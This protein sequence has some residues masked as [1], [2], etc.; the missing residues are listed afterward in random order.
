VRRARSPR[1]ADTYAARTAG[2]LAEREQRFVPGDGRIA[3]A[4]GSIGGIGRKM[5]ARQPSGRRDLS[6]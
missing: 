5:G 4:G 1:R 2:C 3:C 6:I